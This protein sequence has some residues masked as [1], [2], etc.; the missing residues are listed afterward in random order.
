MSHE[1]LHL[2]HE[3]LLHLLKE[4]MRIRIIESKCSELYQR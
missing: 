1:K 4:M 3:H 2:D